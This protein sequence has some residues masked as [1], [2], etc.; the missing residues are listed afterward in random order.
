MADR[1]ESSISRRRRPGRRDGGDRRLRGLP[2]VDRR[3]EGG[4]GPLA[5]RPTGAPR[6]SGSTSTRAPSRTS[7]PSPTPGR[8][9]ARSAGS[10]SRPSSIVKAMDGA[11]LLEDNGDGTHHGDL[12]AGRRRQDPDARHDQAQGRE[13]HHRHRAQ[14]A[15]EAGGGHDRGST[16]LPRAAGRRAAARLAGRGGGQAGRRRAALAAAHRPADR[17]CREQ[18]TTR[19]LRRPTRRSATS[20]DECRACPICRARRF[21]RIAGPRG[22][23][24]PLR[25]AWPRSA[26]P[27]PRFSRTARPAAADAGDGMT[28]TIG[29]D[30]GGTKIAGG[31]VDEEGRILAQHRVHDPARDAAGDDDAIVA[32]IEELRSRHARH[33]GGRAS[34]SPDSST[35]RARSS[36][37]RPTC[38]A[39]ATGRCARRSS[40]GS[41]CP[42]SSRTTPT[43]PPGASTASAPAATRASSSASPS[44]PAS[45]AASSSAGTLRRG[46]F[47]V[48]AEFGHIQMVADGRLCGCGSRLLGAVRQRRR[49]RPR[50]QGARR[51]DRR[52][53]ELL[54][55]LGDGTP[56]GIEGEHVTEA[57]RQGDPVAVDAFDTLGALGRPGA[58]R[59]G[60][61]LRPA[62][63]SSSA[64]GSPTTASW[65]STRPASPTRS[66]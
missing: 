7:T 47:G 56:E 28:L 60:L 20:P 48:A 58:G 24:P 15:Q 17:R 40:S 63:S 61:A 45:A 42:S 31:V 16:R 11:Y 49:P 1:T 12:P 3:R 44:A 62:R 6:R 54:L 13:G 55:G 46:G 37:S 21:A 18:P 14:G 26:G 10:W 57:A 23:R 39:G 33:R 5:A 19:G 29:V 8:P 50:R 51:G 43:R 2:G 22:P 66:C 9:T 27:W 53:A 36:T 65:S 4:R 30:I 64:A 25:R 35:R 38:S 52:R 41:A 32:V 59:P 34:A